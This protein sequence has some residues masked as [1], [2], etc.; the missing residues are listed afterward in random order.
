MS[1]LE[2]IYFTLDFQQGGTYLQNARN[3]IMSKNPEFFSEIFG[4][5]PAPAFVE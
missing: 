2:A 5:P 4:F 1:L 3:I